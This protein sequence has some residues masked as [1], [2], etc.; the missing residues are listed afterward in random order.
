M[1]ICGSFGVDEEGPLSANVAFDTEQMD[2]LRALIREW[3]KPLSP[4]VRFITSKRE[5]IFPKAEIL[6]PYADMY[7]DAVKDIDSRLSQEKLRRLRARNITTD[8]FCGY[9]TTGSVLD[10][11]KR[12]GHP[13]PFTPYFLNEYC[14]GAWQDMCERNLMDVLLVIQAMNVLE[15]NAGI[16]TLHRDPAVVES[17][18]KLVLD[19]YDHHGV[20]PFFV[21]A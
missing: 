6:Q 11:R 10:Q 16:M 2:S 21:M 9:F 7:S 20:P 1:T 13:A 19:L 12:G 14:D 3:N 4:E 5:I 8:N 18:S 17:L 15:E